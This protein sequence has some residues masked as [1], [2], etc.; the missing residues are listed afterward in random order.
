[1][2]R[3]ACGDR[4]VVGVVAARRVLALPLQRRCCGGARAAARGCRSVLARRGFAGRPPEL[5]DDVG[6]GGHVRRRR[7]ITVGPGGVGAP[8][9][10]R[11]NLGPSR[12]RRA[13][14][15]PTTTSPA[16]NTP[17]HDVCSSRRRRWRPLGRARA[18]LERDRCVAGT[19]DLHD[20]A[21]GLHA[22]ALPVGGPNE[23]HGLEAV[24]TLQGR[25]LPSRRGPRCAAPG[26]PA[27]RC[28]GVP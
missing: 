6:D 11:A 23:R 25:Q 22:P 8:I 5:G 15:H 12:L 27:R 21:S 2:S 20:E 17:A 13:R 19:G 7:G 10:R 24:A 4:V 14:T 28:R 1:M 26:E 16:A 18:G 3:L 9:G